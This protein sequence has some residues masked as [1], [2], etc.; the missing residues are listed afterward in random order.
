MS[1]QSP[2]HPGQFVRCECLEPLGLS[3]TAAARAPGV[4]RQALNNV[5]NAK[6]GISPGMAVRLS[7]AFGGTPETWLRLQIAYDLTQV[8]TDGI[9]VRRVPRAS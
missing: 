4:S 8:H 1:L 6:A 7:L 3:V 2:I 5:V 9:D